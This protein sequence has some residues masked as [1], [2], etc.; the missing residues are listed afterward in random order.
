MKQSLDMLALVVGTEKIKHE[1]IFGKMNM[2]LQK[3]SF[4]KN[5]IL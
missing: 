1:I 4:P 3:V 5:I 2:K